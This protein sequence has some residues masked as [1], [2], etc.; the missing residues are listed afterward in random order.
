[1]FQ[2][3]KNIIPVVILIIGIG[4]FGYYFAN[5]LGFIKSKVSK[6]NENNQATSTIQIAPGVEAEIIETVPKGSENIPKPDLNR[7]V[8]IPSSFSAKAADITKKKI[9]ELIVSLKAD[10]TSYENWNELATRRKMIEDYKGAE[11]IW[12]Y[13]TKISPKN[14]IAYVNLGDLYGYYLHDNKKAE[15]TFLSGVEVLPHSVELYVRTVDF[16][17]VIMK[18]PE[19]ARN[20]LKAS[21]VKYPDMELQL[22]PILEGIK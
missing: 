2:N 7:S 18:D 15:A 20:F 9:Q 14:F 8:V 17:T 3:K 4:I 16:Y 1:M 13:L 6:E 5:D 10:P 22:N 11:E 21:M 12:I 19:K